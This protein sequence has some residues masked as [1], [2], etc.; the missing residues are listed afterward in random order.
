M[1]LHGLGEFLLHAGDGLLDVAAQ[2]VGNGF[3]MRNR[4][5]DVVPHSRD[6]VL[7]LYPNLGIAMIIVGSADALPCHFGADL[8]EQQSDRPQVRQGLFCSQIDR[9]RVRTVHTRIVA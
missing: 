8:I 1:L 7:D 4:R 3:E 5:S 2:L 9:A 6:G